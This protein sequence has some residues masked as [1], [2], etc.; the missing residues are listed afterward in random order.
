MFN[1]TPAQSLHWLMGV[2]HIDISLFDLFFMLHI[3]KHPI[4]HL[5]ENKSVTIPS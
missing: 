2:N 5:K 4:D 1:D 3:A